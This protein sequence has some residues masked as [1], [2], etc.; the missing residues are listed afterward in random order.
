MKKVFTMI[1]FSFTMV[2]LNAQ[3]TSRITIEGKINASINDN[4]EGIVVLNKNTDKGTVT[5]EKGEFKIN[6][7]I[8]D[9]VEVISVQYERFVVLIDQGVIENRRMAIFLNE[10]VNE[11]EEVVVRPYDLLGNIRVDA[12][13]IKVTPL[14]KPDLNENLIGIDKWKE[15]ANPTMRN[16]ALDKEML[17]NG[18][19]FVNLFKLVIKSKNKKK[20]KNAIPKD[21]VDTK[22]REMYNDQFFKENLKIDIENINEFIFYAEEKGLNASYF[23]EG[24]ELELLEFLVI[25]SENYKK[26]Q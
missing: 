7:G 17:V 25:Q 10:S 26:N 21:D 11:L 3:I 9:I 2:V 4:V 5:N 8:D 1:L 20:D 6:A 22:I 18:L 23:K 15:G 16:I 14:I 12:K 24:K 13:K 19:N